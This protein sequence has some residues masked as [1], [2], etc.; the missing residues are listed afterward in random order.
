MKLRYDELLSNFAFNFKLRRY[1]TV[2]AHGRAAVHTRSTLVTQAA[3]SQYSLAE[4]N[5]GA[6][7]GRHDLGWAVQVDSIKIRVESAY[8][9]SD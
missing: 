6:K 9:F 2:Q 5:V 1:T 7:L 4:I 8:G 3:D